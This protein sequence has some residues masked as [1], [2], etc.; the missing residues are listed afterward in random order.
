MKCQTD[1]S[2]MD[3][4]KMLD[5][6]STTTGEAVTNLPNDE[7][8]SGA[9]ILV[10]DTSDVPET[11]QTSIGPKPSDNPFEKVS[12]LT[13]TEPD[14]KDNP[15]SEPFVQEAALSP[16]PLE[17]SAELPNDGLPSNSLSNVGTLESPKSP[18][19]HANGEN[20]NLLVVSSD[21]PSP[22]EKDGTPK[23]LKNTDSKVGDIDTA[24]PFESVKE[25]VTKF[26]GIVDW[27]A[28]KVQTTEVYL[29]QLFTFTSFVRYMLLVS[30]P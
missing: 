25:A 13:E 29:L 21:D 8:I 12:T 14:E 26:G 17:E 20:G 3:E 5:E 16:V 15:T 6:V 11:V 9:S 22:I 19:R 18:S 27:K 4:T 1:L 24:S 23:Q 7:P 10:K 2:G 28:H 30:E